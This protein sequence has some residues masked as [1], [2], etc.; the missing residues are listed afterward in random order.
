MSWV[1]WS[2]IALERKYFLRKLRKGQSEPLYEKYFLKALG[3]ARL[4]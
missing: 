1:S 3:I 2:K 4:T